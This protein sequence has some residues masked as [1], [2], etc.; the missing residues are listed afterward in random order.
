MKYTIIVINYN[1]EIYLK[2]C[3]DSIINQNY[4]N[5]ELIIVDDGSTDNSKKIID[6]YKIYKNVKIYY[7]KN[8]GI[9][10]SRN[11]A[12]SKVKTKYF[13]FVDSD[14]Y[15]DKNLL[16]TISEYKNYDILS[17]N[18]FRVNKNK[19]KPE[20]NINNFVSNNG[21]EV[22]FSYI[23]SRALF[24]VPWGYIYNINLFKDYNL[25]YAKGLVHEDVYLTTLL[26]LNAKK[27]ISLN[28]Y[29][30]YYVSSKNS[31]MRNNDEKMMTLKIKSMI[32]N[33]KYLKKYFNKNISNKEYKKVFLDYYAAVALYMGNDLNLKKKKE[34]SKELKNIKIYDYFNI[35]TKQGKIK[36]IICKKYIM[37]YYYFY[38]P[39]SI[40]YWKLHDCIMLLVQFRKR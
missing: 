22:L 4:K 19:K 5:F 28:Y 21:Q 39:L 14:D 38:Y 23:N 30:Y 15:I 27:I 40:L 33:F 11:F 18:C 20:K 10:D 12:I 24:L 13:T 36:Y 8:T 2:K 37:L 17:F 9:S 1:K 34:Y 35:K 16:K 3:L 31:I 26:I 7:K 25:K 29:G 6:S 32:F